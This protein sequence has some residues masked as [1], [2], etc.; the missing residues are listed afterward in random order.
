[1]A[2]IP[3]TSEGK[4]NQN[5][6]NDEAAKY[7]LRFTNLKKLY[8]P[9]KGSSMLSFRIFIGIKLTQVGGNSFFGQLNRKK[10]RTKSTV[11]NQ[12]RE[13]AAGSLAH[14]RPP[15][16]FLSF[17]YN[18]EKRKGFSGGFL[19]WKKINDTLTPTAFGTSRGF[20]CAN[21]TEAA[22]MELAA[23]NNSFSA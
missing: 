12:K 20:N 4:K 7:N 2:F 11:T 15:L 21:L 19:T 17:R 9:K 23:P 18:G 5:N 1:M 16:F 10:L 3:N 6:K 13:D 14:T 22:S 8:T